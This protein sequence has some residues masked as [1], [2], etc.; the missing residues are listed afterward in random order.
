[1]RV[2]SI[3][4][5]E[6]TNRGALLGSRYGLG[7]LTV[8]ALAIVIS[9]CKPV[10]P[11]YKRPGYDAPPAYKEGGASSAVL[12]PPNPAGGGWVPASPS[13]GMLRGKWWEVYQESELNRLEE[14]VTTQ[15][16]TL[17][18]A[19]ENYLAARDQVRV[20][21]AAFYPTLSVGSS[22]THEKLSQNRPL[23][24]VSSR[25]NYNDLLLAG[26]A[27]WEPDF[28]GRIRRTVEA[29]RANA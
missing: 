16:Q 23:T 18:A 17:Q 20:A 11:N 12:P 25:S 4:A 27:S 10:G 9:G 1:M 8:T 3:Q 7:V 21:R 29:A 19:L 6:R 28:W 26:Q 22:Y 14:L 24:T 13:D 2:S 5:G 15:N